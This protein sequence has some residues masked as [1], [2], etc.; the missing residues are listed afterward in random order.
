MR[1]TAKEL[2]LELEL[3]PGRRVLF[4][5][6]NRDLVFWRDTVPLRRGPGV[7]L[8]PISFLDC[9]QGDGGERGRLIRA[10]RLF[11]ASS[12]ADRVHF[13]PFFG[14]APPP[15]VT[16]TDGRDLESY[17]IS[18]NCLG[19]ICNTGFATNRETGSALLSLL[20]E[21]ARP[22]GILRIASERAAL[23]LP[24]QRTL[25]EQRGGIKDLL[26]K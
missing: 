20:T 2:L 14:R 23:G 26:E 25:S 10:A 6:G 7:V 1:W 22:I 19:H 15:N 3:D 16:F 18:N 13:F 11:Q 9:E 4:L 5:E 17:A 24:F 21:L 8:Y 12:A